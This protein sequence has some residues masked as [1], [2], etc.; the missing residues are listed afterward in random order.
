MD[1]IKLMECGIYKLP[2]GRQF[3]VCASGEDAY[4]L[5]SQFSWDRFGLAEYR[6]HKDG[7]ILSRSTPTRWRVEDLTYT[8]RIVE[9][10]QQPSPRS[11]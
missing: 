1:K 11:R 5:Y 10:Y 2:D 6:I 9:L 7:R 8:G 3:V 4:S